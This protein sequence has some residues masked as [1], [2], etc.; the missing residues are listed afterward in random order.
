[1]IR[2]WWVKWCMCA[3]KKGALEL[4]ELRVGCSSWILRPVWQ[5]LRVWRNRTA[6]NS[7]P[8]GN[9]LWCVRMQQPGEHCQVPR[10]EERN[11]RPQ[12]CGG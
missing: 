10:L 11:V 6:S 8:G 12:E 2:L 5:P 9:D 7:D 3:V 1:M 4:L